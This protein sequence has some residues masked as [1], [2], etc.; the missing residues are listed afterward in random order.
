MKK[1]LLYGSTDTR[2]GI[3]SFIHRV[4][5]SLEGRADFSLLQFQ[6]TQI[7]DADF[8]KNELNIPIYKVIVPTD[9]KSRLTGR[10]GY[11]FNEFF[12]KHTFDIVHINENSPAAYYIA[13]A[14][15]KS[16]AEV[17][18][19]SHNGY[20]SSVYLKRTPSWLMVLIRKFQRNQLK[21]L[22]VKKV[23]VS[24]IASNWM[25][26]TT[27]GV[28]MLWN[29]MDMSTYAFLE[30]DRE[31]LRQKLGWR[32]TD[33]VG[34]VAGRIV[35]Q[36]N[37]FYA[38]DIAIESVKAG[39]L[40][41]VAFIGEGELRNEFQIRL[42]KLPQKLREKIKYYGLQKNIREWYA[43][44][45]VMI[46]PSL[47]EGLPYSVVE[48][49]ANG[50]PIVLSDTITKQVKFTDLLYFTSLDNKAE[51]VN[52]IKIATASK[53]ERVQFSRIG[54]NSKFSEKNFKKT[55]EKLYQLQ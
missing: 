50:L 39:V 55:L 7:V 21:A 13:K 47:F 35:K 10:R 9:L 1:I 6:E 27:S 41:K 42:S 36:K 24:D 43:A 16:G 37:I 51:W 8:Y 14:A 34:L 49:Q 48:A 3:E 29:G 19:Q 52:Q 5:T 28:L 31:E 53:Y 22:P 33:V 4:I 44:S 54:Q 12:K 26:E 45:D 38:L 18:Y 2:G 20:A 30:R 11:M 25:F 23:A 17:I 32:E 15:L 46:M 40:D